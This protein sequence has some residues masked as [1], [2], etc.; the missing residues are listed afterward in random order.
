MQVPVE[1]LNAF[2][3][4]VAPVLAATRAEE[5]CIAYAYAEDL[6]EPGLIHLSEV[7]RDKAAYE[8]HFAQPHLQ[9]WLRDREVLGVHSRRLSFYDAAQTAQID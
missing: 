5:G 3:E 8:R 2:R 6:A 4:M 1:N 7:W 9:S